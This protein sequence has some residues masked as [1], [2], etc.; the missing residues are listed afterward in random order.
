MDN[1]RYAPAVHAW[2]LADG[3]FELAIGALLLLGTLGGIT[4]LPVPAIAQ[5]IAGALFLLFG[6]GLGWAA[7]QSALA[8]ATVRPLALVNAAVAVLLAVWLGV[9][10]TTFSG[11]GAA[12][13]AAASV[14]FLVLAAG[15]WRAA[16]RRAAPS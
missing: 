7:F 8:E 14:G 4:S 12:F 10:H 9:A 1:E 16:R 3:A 13:V 6:A 11:V 2:I 5:A 15:E